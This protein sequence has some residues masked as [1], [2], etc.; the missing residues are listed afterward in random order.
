MKAVTH[1]EVYRP[2]KGEFRR[3]PMAALTLAWSGIRIGFRKKMPMLVLFLIPAVTTIVFSF[4]VQL[5]FL[6]LIHI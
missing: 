5:K 2:F 3:F 6:S 1:T 4:M